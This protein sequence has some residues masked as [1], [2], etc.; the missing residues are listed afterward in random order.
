MCLN[1]STDFDKLDVE[2][3]EAG[4]VSCGW[5]FAVGHFGGDPEAAGFAFDHELESFGPACDDA[6]EREGGGLAA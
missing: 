6:V 1:L 4:G 3:E 5:V 2:Y